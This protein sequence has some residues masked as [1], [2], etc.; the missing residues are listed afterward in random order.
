MDGVLGVSQI[1]SPTVFSTVGHHEAVAGS[2]SDVHLSV[3]V[4]VSKA[5]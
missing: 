1:V 4:S 5:M 2:H 3:K